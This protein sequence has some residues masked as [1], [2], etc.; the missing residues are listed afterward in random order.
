MKSNNSST[1]T[2]KKGD[3]VLFIENKP[4]VSRK[5]IE[6]IK[7]V[8]F[9]IWDGEK[10]QLNDR[11]KTIVRKKEWLIKLPEYYKKWITLN[12]DKTKK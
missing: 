4:F 1:P 10:V 5:R 3:I 7:T 8:A 11:E 9:G 12:F 2:I 6:T